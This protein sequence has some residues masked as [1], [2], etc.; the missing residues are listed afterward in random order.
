M[1]TITLQ[2]VKSCFNAKAERIALFFPFLQETCTKYQIN[3]PT[4]VAAFFAQLAIES[5]DLIYTE[6]IASGDSYTSRKDLGNTL[7]AAIAAY[8][9]AVAAGFIHSLGAFYK[10]R[11][12]IQI[13]GYSNYSELGEALKIDLVN[14]PILLST[15]ELACKSA[16]WF[17]N[18]KNL[19]SLAD[20]GEFGKIT[21]L[22]NGGY[23]KAEERLKRFVIN[24]KVL[25]SS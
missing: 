15:P 16:G 8:N 9:A 22:I 20:V 14:N 19:N 3:T 6:E 12:L 2:D 25:G 21:Y 11:G 24:N 13:T 1:Y 17:W 18:T 5:L 7:P 23:N 4:R 10:G